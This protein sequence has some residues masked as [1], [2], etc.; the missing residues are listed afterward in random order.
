[1]WQCVQCEQK[2]CAMCDV[3][4]HKK[5]AR[6]RHRRNPLNAKALRAE[7]MANTDADGNLLVPTFD[8]E[9]DQRAECKFCGRRFNP[10]RVEKHMRICAKAEKKW[11]KRK[12]Y[13]GAKKRIE[14]T[15][16]KQFEY[17]RSSTPE[18]VKEWRK[19]GRRW[20]E[21]SAMLRGAAGVPELDL[22]EKSTV[23]SLKIAKKALEQEEEFLKAKEDP[24]RVFKKALETRISLA[25]KPRKKTSPPSSGRSANSNNSAK[26]SA[27]S[28][29]RSTGRKISARSSAKSSN[30]SSAR[31]SVASNVSRNRRP[32][33]SMKEPAKVRGKRVRASNDTTSDGSS[34]SSRSSARSSVRSSARS[35]FG[36][37]ASTN[38]ARQKKAVNSKEMD[39]TTTG[40]SMRGQRRSAANT[41]K[42][43]VP[44]F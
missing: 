20:K 31:S 15:E 16:F 25:P 44:K 24:K 19:H 7:N 38:S 9:K 21:E 8:P 27:T 37:R 5:G 12:P 11:Q 3:E 4:L 6:A 35:S 39:L 1:M 40:S 14:G 29:A 36:S 34:F 22:E 10:D 33:K 23:R 28:S 17:N 42:P 2:L 18:K 43:G 26:S 30:A 41:R 13:D 32:T